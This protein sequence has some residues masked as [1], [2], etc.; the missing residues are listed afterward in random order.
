[1]KKL[2]IYL[3]IVAVLFA[4]LFVI[5]QSSGSSS[6]NPYDI[7]ERDLN[8]STRKQL[9][10]V[11]YQNIILPDEMKSYTASADGAFVYFF[12]PQC[13]FCVATT[14]LLMPLADELGVEIRQYNLLE[15]NEG[16][17]AYQITHTPTLAYFEN[18][19]K[20]QQ[21]VG[22][23]EVTPGDGGNTREQITA[24]LQKDFTAA[25]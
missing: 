4:G 1:M 11:H 21:I 3:A 15:F 12:S 19:V 14:P 5:N 24:F 22:G 16:W 25:D 18:G 9:D 2:M 8:P 23:M 20:L 10:D 6:D 17:S 7:K 13:S